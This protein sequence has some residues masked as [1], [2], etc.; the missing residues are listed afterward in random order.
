MRE[1]RGARN[2]HSQASHYEVRVKGHLDARWAAWFDGM[3]LQ[4]EA[5]GVTAI[6]G[7]VAD[8]AALH[9]MLQRVRDVGIPLVS[10]TRVDDKEPH[11]DVDDG[12]QTGPLQRATERNDE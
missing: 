9:G 2:P 4:H 6:H 8:Q 11:P 7:L 1:R 12:T 3:S 10:V 5:D